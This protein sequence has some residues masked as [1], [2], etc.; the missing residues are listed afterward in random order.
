M[1]RVCFLLRV[2]PDRLDEYK[3]RHR[4]GVAGDARRAARDRLGQLLA[5]PAPTTGCSSATSRPRT[6]T[7]ALARHGG[8]R[9]QRPL[10]GR[11]GGVLRRSGA[12]RR[13][14]APRGGL[15][16]CL[17]SV[18]RDRPRR[19]QRARGRRRAATAGASRSRRSTASPNRPVRLPDGL[20][21]NLLHLFTEALDGP[22]PRRRRSAGV[23]VDTWGVDYALLDGA[24]PRARAAV[25][26]PRRAHR[27]DGRARVRAR[28]R[29][30]SC[31]P[32]PASR[33][34]RSTP[35]SSCSPTRARPRSRAAERIALVPD[36]LALWL[37][38][39]AGQRAHQRLDHRAARR[40]QRRVGARG[41]RAARAARAGC[42]ATLVE[43]GTALGPLLAHHELGA[44]AG[45][46]GRQPRHRLGV[47][48]RAGARRARRD[49][50]ERHL[51]A[52]RARAARAG[53]HR[54]RA[55]GEPHQRARR[56]RHDAAAQERHGP[57]AAGGVPARVGRRRPTTSCTG[58]PRRR[59]ATCRC[60][61]PT[62]TR[63]SRPGD[64][65]ARIAAACERTGQRAPRDRGETVR[66]ILVSLA[67]KYRWV[68]ER[69]EAV[70]GRDVH[71]IHVD[72]RRRAQRAAVP[73]DR[74]RHAAARCSPAPVEA[75]A[76][77]NVLVQARAAGELGS[78]ADMR[79]VAAASAEPDRPR[80]RPD[81]DGPRRPTGASSTSP[82]CDAPPLRR[83]T[84][85]P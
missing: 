26:L 74:R 4:D 13:A 32:R 52:A 76:L 81:R 56:R 3:E 61:T 54:R 16:P 83:R 23:G 84:M 35:S 57:V 6:S 7:A 27:R 14:R 8:D 51:V 39:R 15:P 53:A 28:A 41:D 68:L 64:M 78:L 63:S 42:S 70:S 72:R 82:A 12:R 69:L 80:A 73:A 77:G 59:P 85:H 50:L 37:S 18:R 66:A 11:D 1:E 24:R 20:R 49:P 31:T 40:A 48:R 44:A 17:S 47:R 5:V 46:R 79:A 62:T 60:S 43:P 19:D 75:T 38:R 2:R 30:A 36:L 67:C 33:R 65:P 25:P 29:R 21:W 10:A 9:R 45:L 22:A 58:S 71:R 55:R 34:C